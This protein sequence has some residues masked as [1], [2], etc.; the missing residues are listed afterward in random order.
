MPLVAA[1][2]VVL[3]VAAPAAGL[4]VRDMLDRD[5]TLAAPPTRIV[6]LVPSATEILFGLGADERLVGVTDYCNF[7]PE[8]RRKPSVGGM[9]SPSLETIAALR[10][11]LVIATDEGN[12]EETFAQLARLRIP[13]FLVRAHRLADVA[14][15][16]TR[17]AELTGRMEAARAMIEPMRLR[18]DAVRRA[19]APL[20]KPRVLYVVWPDPLIVPGRDA[21]VTDLIAVAGGASITAGDGEAYPRFSLEAAIARNPEVII[22]ATHGAGTG[23]VAKEKFERFA[24]MAA[25]RA[26][27]LHTADGDLMHRYTPRVVD[28]LE[29]LARAIHPEAFP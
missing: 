26:G 2:L 15:V 19:V 21:I 18:V 7:P 6:S 13:T 24:S 17:L 27:R 20:P 23:K 4:T 29:R 1:L 10:P 9:V 14:T 25:V 5:V 12:R 16:I 28:G 22:L 11:H 8:A 3:A